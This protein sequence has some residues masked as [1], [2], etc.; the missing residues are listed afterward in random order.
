MGGSMPATGK[1]FPR[2]LLLTIAITPLCTPAEIE[3]VAHCKLRSKNTERATSSDRSWSVLDVKFAV[4]I[5][6]VPLER[7]L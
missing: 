3:A 6:E 5:V 2:H 7:A 1:V 4:D